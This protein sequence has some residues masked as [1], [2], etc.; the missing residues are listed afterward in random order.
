MGHFTYADVAGL[1]RDAK[2]KDSFVY[3][4]EFV[5]LV[6]NAKALSGGGSRAVKV[7]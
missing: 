4:Q 7:E 2:G 6:E 5:E 1:A 3:R